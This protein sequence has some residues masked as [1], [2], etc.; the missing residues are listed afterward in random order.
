MVFPN[1]FLS[2]DRQI[3][4][5]N[6]PLSSYNIIE[7]IGLNKNKKITEVIVNIL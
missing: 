5:D 6:K 2:G 1:L 7:I 4:D 3:L